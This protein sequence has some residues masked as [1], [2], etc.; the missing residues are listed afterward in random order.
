MFEKGGKRNSKTNFA[1][2]SIPCARIILH[3]I[4]YRTKLTFKLILK[5][6]ALTFPL[7][8]RK[9]RKRLSKNIFIYL[10]IFI[11]RRGNKNLVY[12]FYFT[13]MR[14]VLFY[15][16][17]QNE[18]HSLFIFFFKK[19]LNSKKVSR[20]Y[21]KMYTQRYELCKIYAITPNCTLF[22]KILSVIAVISN[23]S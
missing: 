21:V 6:W 14:M 4:K 19:W 20:K 12:F 1:N 13:Q 22:F 5:G 8:R 7:G 16:Y 10:W 17:R 18:G 23:W 2:L 9:R 15:L 3:L 11:K